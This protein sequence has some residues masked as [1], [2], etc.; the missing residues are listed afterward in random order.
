M[1]RI[2][3]QRAPGLW[4][5][6]QVPRGRLEVDPAHPLAVGLQGVFMP[7]SSTPFLNIANPATGAITLVNSGGIA[8]GPSGLE[9]ISRTAATE[10]IAS[11]ALH[12]SLQPAT[13]TFYA[14]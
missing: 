4:V 10:A 14:R 1:A 13:P 3:A 9:F 8:P 11:G 6:R 7:G 5:P 2:H 12:A